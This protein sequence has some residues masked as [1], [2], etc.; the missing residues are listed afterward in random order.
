[1]K[2]SLKRWLAFERTHGDARGVAE[3]QG[4]AKRYVE[5]AAGGGGNDGEEEE[6]EEE[7]MQA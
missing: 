7:G 2:F 4:V 1:M 3:V 5:A 6:E